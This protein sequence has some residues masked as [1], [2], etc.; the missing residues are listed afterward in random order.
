MSKLGSLLKDTVIYG[1]SSIVGRF[2]NYLLVPLYTAKMSVESGEYGVVTNMYAWTAF[3]LVVLI[4]GMET[5]FFRF[6]DRQKGN[7]SQVFSMCLQVVGV[8]CALFLAGVFLNIGSLAPLLGYASHPE[9]ITMMAVVVALDA[10]QSIPFGLLRFQ[11]RP[12]KFASLKMLNIITNI[13]LNLIFFLLLPYLYG[14]NPD[15][16]SWLYS[17]DR[18]SYYV[19]LINLVCTSFI[20]LFF[21]P[22]L[23]MYRPVHDAALLKKML[24]YSWPLLLLGIAGILNLNAD[25][26]LYPQLVPGAQGR[27]ELSVYGA[28]VKIAA[29]M[30]MLMQAFR[31]AYEPFVFGNRD[32]EDSKALYAKAMKY[33]IAVALFAFL[34]VVFYMDLIKYIISPD[35]W[36]G[37]KVVPLVMAAEIFMGIYFNLSFWYK[38]NDETYWGALFSFAGCAILFAINILFVPHY[39]YMA[40]AWA[41]FTAYLVSMLLSYFVGRR[42]NNID[43]DLKA[44]FGYVAIFLLLYGASALLPVE[45][46]ILR[47]S[48]NTLLLIVYLCYFVKRDLPLKSIPFV[49]RLFR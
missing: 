49:N 13:A 10:L 41:S 45:N 32:K 14:K 16:V 17:P 25:K 18:Q 38:L 42:R 8:L 9:F 35:Y 37:L 12:I 2:L 36:A 27:A 11:G 46:T 5:T 4:F 40:C 44:I 20:T 24:S 43:Y 30:A 1:M 29:I 31:F 3:I 19:F 7:V 33:F 34:C 28:S 48:C 6:A 26:I 21:I 23:R 22:E 39:G 47:L 15:S